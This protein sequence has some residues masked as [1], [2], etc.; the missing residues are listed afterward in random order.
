MCIAVYATKHLKIMFTTKD[1][2]H[3]TIFVINC[4]K[5]RN[6]RVMNGELLLEEAEEK[7]TLTK[8]PFQKILALFIIGHISVTTPLIEKCKKFGVALIVVKPN[9]RPVFYWSDSAEANF[10]LRRQQYLFA[11]DDLHVAKALLASKVQNQITLLRNTRRKD[12]LTEKAIAD[13]T[14]SLNQILAEQDY[15]RLMGLEALAS[16]AF[17][18]AYFQDLHWKAR[19]PR[20]KCDVL[21]VSLDIGYTILF[22]FVECYLRM[23]GF[24]LY[25]G[26]FHRL[27]FKRKSL[28]CDV[29]EPFRCIIDRAVR[30]AF[31]RKQFQEK[32]FKR[33]KGEWLL[34][35][36]CSQDYYKVFVEALMPFKTELFRF[37][38]AYYRA[39]MRKVSTNDYPQFSISS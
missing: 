14:S 31:H 34:R 3:R 24:D 13:C 25:V 32:D 21:N 23:F 26:V 6:L 17:F 22:N 9:L 33:D 11:K 19:C 2:E 5:E 10:L 37:I 4:I 27:W 12:Q 7:R 30:T 35:R 8:M 39:F 20:A 18:S 28:V 36:E 16:K 38:Q 15:Q 1:I 29:M